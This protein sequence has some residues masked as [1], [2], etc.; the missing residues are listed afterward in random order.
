M[1]ISLDMYRQT[2]GSFQFRAPKQKKSSFKTSTNSKFWKGKCTSIPEIFYRL[3]I[4]VIIFSCAK[5]TLTTWKSNQ[6]YENDMIFL[7]Q[8]GITW[9][10]TT[11]NSNKLLHSL[12]G[13]RRNLGYKYFVWNCD[14][15]FLSEKKIDDVKVLVEQKKPHLFAIIEANIFRDEGNKNPESVTNLTTSQ[16][17]EKFQIQ[18]YYIILPD[19]W[20]KHNVARIICY[21]HN[22]IKVKKVN[23]KDDETHLQTV[24]LEIGFG[25]ATTHLVNMYYREW[26]SCVTRKSD[27]ASQQEDLQKLI[28][29]WARCT[30]SQKDFSSLGDLNLCSI[31]N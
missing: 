20:L 27:P 14:R 1:G 13:N 6:I 31:P 15:G 8:R 3:V 30:N 4:Y 21:V 10:F 12:N 22:D 7:N 17:L 16:V 28:N 26:K 2:I 29:I 25:R 9:S 11:N 5:W 24:L 23:L 18:N 19:S